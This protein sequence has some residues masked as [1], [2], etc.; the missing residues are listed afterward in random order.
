MRRLKEHSDAL[1]KRKCELMQAQM[2][3]QFVAEP[4]ATQIEYMCLQ[5]VVEGEVMVTKQQE[6][7]LKYQTDLKIA[8]ENHNRAKKSLN[9]EYD[10]FCM[11]KFKTLIPEIGDDGKLTK[12]IYEG[13][14]EPERKNS[15]VMGEVESYQD[16]HE[17]LQQVLMM[18]KKQT[19][20]KRKASKKRWFI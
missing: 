16:K 15:E 19:A 10:R 6:T 11:E 5:K 13:G 4:A 3:K 7:V 9:D 2:Q 1:E 17:R 18:E 12:T 20:A 14:D 8:V